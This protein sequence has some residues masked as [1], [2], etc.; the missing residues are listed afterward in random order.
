MNLEVLVGALSLVQAAKKNYMN[1]HEKRRNGEETMENKEE[2]IQDLA[3]KM[4]DAHIAGIKERIEQTKSARVQK[5]LVFKEE[6]IKERAK[7]AIAAGEEFLTS[8]END[9]P[10]K[11]PIIVAIGLA[12]L[13][14]T[15]IVFLAIE[16]GVF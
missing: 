9:K 1:D 16:K 13:W 15:Y 10:S 12:A 6:K 3:K 7:T 14:V 4:T 5:P 2:E 8:F 11:W